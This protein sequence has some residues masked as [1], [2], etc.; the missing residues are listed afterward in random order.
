MSPLPLKKEQTMAT[1]IKIDGTREAIQ[2]KNGKCF[3]LEELQKQ[4]GGFIEYVGL[5]EEEIMVI[6]EEGKLMNLAVN[7][8]ATDIAL[9]NEAITFWDFIVGD[10]VICKKSELQ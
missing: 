5:S 6:N 4:V 9:D 7:E 2:P 1:L 8:N 3:K 10:V